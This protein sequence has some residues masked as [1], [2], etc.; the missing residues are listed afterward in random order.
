[1]QF[2]RRALLVLVVLA[3][4]S[5]V[6]AW[7]LAGREAGPAIEVKSPAKFI[8]QAGSLELF[9]DAPAGR[10][11]RLTATRHPGRPGHPGIRARRRRRASAG[12][13]KQAS[14]DRLW[15]IRP[16]GKAAQPA[17]VPGKATLTVTRSAAGALWPA[18]SRHRP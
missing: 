18:G 9:V 11:T 10:L 12:D 1:M 2:M 15:V 13:V 5:A 7:L 16:L 3:L 17:L 8:G 14:S 4:G 6:A